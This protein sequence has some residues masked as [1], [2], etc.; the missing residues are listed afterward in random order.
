MLNSVLLSILTEK[1]KR[2]LPAA[3]PKDAWPNSDIYM[4][5][6]QFWTRYVN[7]KNKLPVIKDKNSVK[8][9]GR[10]LVQLCY[11]PDKNKKKAQF[12]VRYNT[13][14]LIPRI[15]VIQ[16]GI[17]EGGGR[18][19]GF[20][21]DNSFGGKL[22][23]LLNNFDTLTILTI[24]EIRDGDDKGTHTKGNLLTLSH[25]NFI[26]LSLSSEKTSLQ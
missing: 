20:R 23:L 2:M 6:F 8:C 14:T 22:L 9:E 21:E 18:D 16:P 19:G 12:A 25:I 4:C 7:K 11:G 17:P 5:L 26:S 13:N 1:Q 24:I 10:N 3:Q 15:Y